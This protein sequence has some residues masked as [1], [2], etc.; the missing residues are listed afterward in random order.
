MPALQSNSALYAQPGENNT[1]HCHIWCLCALLHVADL[2]LYFECVL[3][4]SWIKCRIWACVCV[5]YL[6]PTIG[7][8]LQMLHLA[9][10]LAVSAAATLCRTGS[11]TIDWGSRRIQSTN[12]LGSSSTLLVTWALKRQCQQLGAFQLSLATMWSLQTLLKF[13]KQCW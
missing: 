7:H 12:C 1:D 13:N 2:S 6:K 11:Q 4:K 9:W 3:H 8:S 10:C 5:F